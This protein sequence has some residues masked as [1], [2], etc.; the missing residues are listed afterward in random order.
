M[1]HAILLVALLA[2][3]PAAKSTSPVLQCLPGQHAAAATPMECASRLDSLAA[4]VAFLEKVLEGKGID[5]ERERRLLALADSSFEFAHDPAL[6]VGPAKAKHTLTI[7]TDPQ[8]PYC[9]RIYPQLDAWLAAHPDLR[10]AFH[11]FPLSFH[12][13]AMPASRAYWAAA[14]QNKFP[15]YFHALHANASNDL[16]DTALDLAAKSAGM[17]L[18]K[19]QADRVSDASYAAVQQDLALGTRV[20][21]QGTPSLYLDGKASRDPVGDLSRLK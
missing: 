12:E 11:L 1:I 10:I 9:L 21:V 14:R 17:D 18:A 3:K 15:A 4:E 6:V 2:G 19:F 20:G 13:R 7:F 5:F 8:C 16:S